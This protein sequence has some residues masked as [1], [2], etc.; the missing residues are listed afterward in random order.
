MI[1][2]SPPF[3]CMWIIALHAAYSSLYLGC[4]SS[5]QRGCAGASISTADVNTR[6]S[7]SGHGPVIFVKRIE[8]DERMETDI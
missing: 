7:G 3:V 6:N 1:P 4:I 5:D 8:R 2:K